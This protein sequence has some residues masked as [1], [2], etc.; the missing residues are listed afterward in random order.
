MFFVMIFFVLLMCGGFF[1]FF[2]CC[3][4][5]ELKVRDGFLIVVFFWMVIGSVGLLFFWLVN[6]F[7]VFVIDVFFEFFFVLIMIG[8]IVIVGLDELLKVI[9]FYC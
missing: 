8:V 2:N 1:W 3:Y 7:E 6:N 9:L 4:C 5:Y